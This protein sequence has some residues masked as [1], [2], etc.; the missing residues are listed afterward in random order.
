MGKKSG[1]NW[2]QSSEKKTNDAI[3]SFQNIAAVILKNE[4]GLKRNS[5]ALT[6]AIGQVKQFTETR[7]I[8]HRLKKKN[9]YS[10]GLPDLLD[11]TILQL[12]AAIAKTSE[13][14]HG[15]SNGNG[16]HYRDKRVN[17][18]L[19]CD[20]RAAIEMISTLVDNGLTTREEREAAKSI[21]TAGGF[22]ECRKVIETYERDKETKRSKPDRRAGME[23]ER[24]YIQAYIL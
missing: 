10:H 5:K 7:K 11:L 15:Y 17:E 16:A 3:E 20:Q 8:I 1:R 12:E 24:A 21:L 2:K 13:A 9:R 23:T 6:S 14:V 19:R 22:R 4:K 18:K